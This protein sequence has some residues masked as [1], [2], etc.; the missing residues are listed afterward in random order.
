GLPTTAL[1]TACTRL[2]PG[3]D[4][5]HPG[6]A[7][8]AALRRLARRYQQ[9]H[10]EITELDSELA[11]LV[12]AAAPDLLE[13]PGVGV[14]TAGQLLTTRG[15][16]PATPPTGYAPRPP[17]PTYAE[18]PQYRQAPAAPTGTGSTAAATGGPTLLCTSSP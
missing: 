15:P 12:A 11:V 3:T 10:A 5:A 4:L 8:K 1:V 9:L 7:T 2:R 17:S 16:P 18:P 14:E 6:R 13:L